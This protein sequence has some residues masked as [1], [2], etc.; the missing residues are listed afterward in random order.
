[1]SPMVSAAELFLVQ[2][3]AVCMPSIDTESLVVFVDA[4]ADAN[5][6]T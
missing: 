5:P 3:L 6:N 1:M 4:D 2:Y